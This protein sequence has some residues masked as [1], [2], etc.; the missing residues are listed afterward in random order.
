MFQAIQE[1]QQQSV[2][3]RARCDALI[4][5]VDTLRSTNS[6][7]SSRNGFLTRKMGELE[8]DLSKK[9]FQLDKLTT[10]HHRMKEDRMNL[11]MRLK[12][13]SNESMTANQALS[14]FVDENRMLKDNLN[15]LQKDYD[16]MAI[17]NRR[18]CE[19]IR[20]L[21][22]LQKDTEGV[23]KNQ[24]DV[25]NAEKKNYQAM[26]YETSAKLKDAISE[27]QKIKYEYEQ[28]KSDLK[29]E[30]LGLKREISTLQSQ[31]KELRP[32]KVIIGNELCDV[33]TDCS[34][35]V[36]S[37]ENEIQLLQSKLNERN[38]MIESFEVRDTMHRNRSVD[39]K[40]SGSY[41]RATATSRAR[42]F[43][44]LATNRNALDLARKLSVSEKKVSALTSKLKS[45]DQE[46]LEVR[47]A[48]ERR[49][50]RFKSLQQEMI[51][52]REQVKTYEKD[53]ESPVVRSL[54]DIS[55][56]NSKEK[57]AKQ[58][59]KMKQENRDLANQK[60]ELQEIVDRL[61]VER[62]RDSALM[63]DLQQNLANE[64]EG[65]S[66][67]GEI[68]QWMSECR[69]LESKIL[70]LKEELIISNQGKD[71]L[72]KEC[73]RLTELSESLKQ[74]VESFERSKRAGKKSKPKVS[75]KGLAAN[76][77]KVAKNKPRN[78][79]SL[80][81]NIDENASLT[82]EDE[83]EYE[84]ILGSEDEDTDTY[85]TVNSS[86]SLGNRI[87]EV[88]Q[89]NKKIERAS[90]RVLNRTSSTQ[91][92]IDLSNAST[93]AHLVGMMS[94]PSTPRDTTI[95]ERTQESYNFGAPLVSKGKGSMQLQG[96]FKPGFDQKVKK[97][98]GSNSS[99]N[100]GSS[101]KSK[102]TI[103]NL[104][105]DVSLL[106]EKCETLTEQNAALRS[107]KVSLQSTID[108]LYSQVDRLQNEQ[109][110]MSSKLRCAK[111]KEQKLSVEV[112][113]LEKVKSELEAKSGT[114]N[115]GKQDSEIRSLESRLRNAQ[116]ETNRLKQEVKSITDEKEQKQNDSKSLQ[117][118]ITRLER[119][120]TQKRSLIE[121]LRF[122]IKTFEENA[123]NDLKEQNEYDAKSH[124]L[125][126]TAESAKRTIENLRSQL[127]HYKS[128]NVEAIQKIEKLEKHIKTLESKK[129]EYENFATEMENVATSQLEGLA[130]QSEVA[131]ER[132][133][134]QLKDAGVIVKEFITLFR[135]FA[136]ELVSKMSKQSRDLSTKK[137]EHH[138]SKYSQGMLAAR[139]KA[140]EILDLST[141]DIDEIM[142]PNDSGIEIYSKTEAYRS[143]VE[144]VLNSKAP[145]ATEMM[146]LLLEV[147]SEY[148][149]VTAEAAVLK[150][151][152]C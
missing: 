51:L 126:E 113:K 17:D 55:K 147:L 1:L 25:Y 75:V 108:G 56:G 10:E 105:S 40:R 4:T 87:K 72:A 123:K 26:Y 93:L 80:L 32:K 90:K 7:L 60:I 33:C 76:K 19:L 8:E 11:D 97:Q 112:E 50:A 12:S 110:N 146:N 52:L 15:G 57:M 23:M 45:A 21:Q 18:Q 133:Q 117:E 27:E 99:T 138:K 70:D 102:Q 136:N 71:A 139:S 109:Q 47:K 61:R 132:L 30:N 120:V 13:Q 58:F 36:T 59:E 44:P 48:H 92:D 86:L 150:M 128:I 9:T 35:K 149:K 100:S 94:N 129:H 2:G 20:Q 14:R 74:S 137:L 73:N 5:E 118:K 127:G 54:N 124:A 83:D 141:D 119:D 134:S 95:D 77:P 145:F 31:I 106:S 38:R 115:S 104:K 116:N 85:Q 65:K 84:E 88:A 142:T 53:G 6:E 64:V 121:N 135:S 66:V 79:L 98:K 67:D 107:A 125:K 82:A 39:Q 81:R 103:K 152:S 24:E 131:I 29:S 62:V 63:Q 111:M 96:S 148:S 16:K 78:N 89:A 34:A 114:D 46:L 122:K 3:F 144:E 101:Y 69:K 42:S 143:R 41:T 68:R 43:S 37:Y 28:M 140:A 49:L 130:M 91:T 151:E 22:N